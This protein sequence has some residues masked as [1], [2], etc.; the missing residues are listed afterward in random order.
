MLGQL[1]DILVTATVDEASTRADLVVEW[2]VDAAVTEA[3]PNPNPESPSMVR[4]ASSSIFVRRFMS[5][6]LSGAD[7]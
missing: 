5:T 1:F 7:S 2:L 6:F 3:I 4:P